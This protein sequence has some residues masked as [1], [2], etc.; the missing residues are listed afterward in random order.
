MRLGGSIFQA[1]T[2]DELDSLV[3]TFDTYGL[4]TVS[5]PWGF[6]QMTDDEVAAYG[7]RA[8][9]LGIVIG[10]SHSRPNLLIRDPVERERRIENLRVGLRK[11][12]IMGAR[13]V[14]ILV[15]TG[16]PEDHLAAPHPFNYTDEARRQFRETLLRAMDG[17]EL[18]KTELSIEPW[19]NTFFYQP[20]AIREFLD[21]VGH[22]KIGLHLDLMNMVDQY[23]YY[24]TTELID[25][26]FDLLGERIGA[27]HFKDLRWD[28]EYMYLKFD[29]VPIGDG[30]IDYPTYVR[31]IAELGRDTPCF[32]EHFPTEGEF[33]ISFA[34]LHRLAAQ[35][36]AQFTPRVDA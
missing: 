4:S 27:V 28:W 21:S 9:E 15:G 24:R 29:E 8:V 10:E 20:E 32:V 1:R 26:T 12:E 19:T 11:A 7:Q 18:E 23:H 36:G 14:C 13:C 34:R 17:L 3:E 35:A 22:P 25:K 6:E 16:G 30:I 5:A 2:P 33:A 31:R